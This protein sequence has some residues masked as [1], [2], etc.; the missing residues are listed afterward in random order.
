M[1]ERLAQEHENKTGNLEQVKVGS[2][3]ELRL[4]D[5]EMLYLRLYEERPTDRGV[6][7]RYEAVSV[8]SPIG[9]AIMRHTVGEQVSYKTPSG[10]VLTL[11]ICEIL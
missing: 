11:E 9:K 5:G 3:V 10:A 7:D 1:N 8:G 4:E 6:D 2:L